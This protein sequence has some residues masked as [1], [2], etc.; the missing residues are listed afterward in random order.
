MSQ[1]QS[2]YIYTYMYIIWDSK[3]VFNV[4]Y[5]LFVEVSLLT[6]CTCILMTAGNACVLKPSEL[7][8]ATSNLLRELVPLYLDQVRSTWTC[9]CTLYNVYKV[10]VHESETGIPYLYTLNF[11]GYRNTHHTVHV[12]YMYIHMYMYMQMSV[13]L[14]LE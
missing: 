4:Q 1:F 2:L 13:F 14:H 3:W 8:V 11:L 5:V 12:Q 10:H 7:S 6:T 9:T